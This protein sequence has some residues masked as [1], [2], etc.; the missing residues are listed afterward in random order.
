MNNRC[1][2]YTAPLKCAVREESLSD[3]GPEQLLVETRC[4]AI[5]AGTEMLVF[6]GR[7][8]AGLPV[9][10]TIPSYAGQRFAYPLA[11][12]YSSVGKVVAAGAQI[13]SGWVGQRVFAF[14]PHQSHYLARA[15]ELIRLPPELPDE[16][17]VFLASMETAVNLV[18]DGRPLLGEQVLLLGQG[19]IGLL[20]TALLARYPLGALAAL[21]RWPLRRQAALDLGAEAA[22]SGAETDFDRQAAAF[23]ERL[24]VE[25][26]ADLVFELSGQP[27][28]LDTAIAWAGFG[29]RI[30]VGSWYGTKAAAIDLGGR[31]HRERIRLMAS[32]VS[33]IDPIHGARWTARRRLDTALAM[34]ARVKPSGLITHRFA[35]DDAQQAL[36]QIAGRPQETLQVLLTYGATPD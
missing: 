21:E 4:S 12:G 17:A 29:A 11:Y 23:F 14:R 36:E 15:D 1:L 25:G 32:Q 22:W 20:T 27:S 10:A 30:V 13:S 34:L 8:P 24:D 35:I 18:M 19:V 3:V 31:F 16:D 26:R 33:T 6:T 9:D 7:I 2:F 5:S 28:M